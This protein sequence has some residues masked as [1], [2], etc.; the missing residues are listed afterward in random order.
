MCSV[1]ATLSVSATDPF[2]FSTFA[3]TLTYPTAG[4]SSSCESCT[5]FEGAMANQYQVLEE[6]GSSSPKAKIIV[7]I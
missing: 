1:A 6:L 4:F 3:L 7:T 5:C 2:G